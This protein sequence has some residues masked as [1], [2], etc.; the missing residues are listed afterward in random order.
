MKQTTF[1]LLF[2]IFAFSVT[3]GQKTVLGVMPFSVS[4]NYTQDEDSRNRAQSIQDMVSASFQKSNRFTLVERSKMN[5]IQAEREIQKGED[6]IDS[7]SIELSAALGAK[8]IVTG[9][10]SA[11]NVVKTEYHGGYNSSY[12]ASILFELKVLDVT[13]GLVVAAEHFKGEGGGVTTTM[14]EKAFNTAFSQVESAVMKF[15][16][17]NFPLQLTIV[18]IQEKNKSGEAK[19]L[20]I[21][22]GTSVGI[23]KGDKLK[24]CE[25]QMIS[26]DGVELPRKKEIGQIKIIK[27]EDENF[28]I[29]EVILGSKEITHKLETKA[30]IKVFLIDEE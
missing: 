29:G 4:T 28:S 14:G 30:P 5:T 6:F 7:K 25:I 27:V 13:T 12:S 17:K 9:N 1:I 11:A 20:L 22:A 3:Y 15:I 24:V 23:V 2:C 8:Y 26:V 18:E 10:I 19:L 16:E 21:A